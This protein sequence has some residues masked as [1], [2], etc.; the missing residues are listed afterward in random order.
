MALL[1]RS[2][3]RIAAFQIRNEYLSSIT[4]VTIRLGMP[5]RNV[6]YLPVKAIPW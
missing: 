1:V 6:H 2:P 5:G 3:A 4:L